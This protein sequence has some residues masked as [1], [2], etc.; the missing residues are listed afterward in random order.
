[1]VDAKTVNGGY[2][3]MIEGSPVDTDRWRSASSVTLSGPGG[4]SQPFSAIVLQGKI[5]WAVYGNDR[6]TTGAARLDSQ[7]QW[8]A[9]SPPCAS[10]GRSYAVPTASTPADLVAVCVIGGFGGFDGGHQ[11]AQVNF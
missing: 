11:W 5:G 3:A 8:V 7:G 6:G 4:G 9:W 10:V 2:G 1:M